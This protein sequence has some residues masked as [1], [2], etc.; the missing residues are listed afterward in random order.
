MKPLCGIAVAFPL[1]MACESLPFVESD[2]PIE[3]IQ[4]SAEP[5]LETVSVSLEKREI[6]V[7]VPPGPPDLLEELRSA[8]ELE[9]EDNARIEAQRNW[10][11]RHPDYLDRVLNRAQRYMP[12]I[13]EELV[14]RELP[15]ELALLPIVESAYDPFA[16][17]H[18]RAAGLWQ[19]IPGTGRRFG[20]EEAAG[21]GLV[22]SVHADPA[23]ARK[24]ALEMAAGIAAKSPLENLMKKN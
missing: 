2:E 20:A 11:V 21:W 6:P 23:A 18:G 1:L 16:Y 12:Y 3:E 4:V 19:I 5:R 15:I 7:W 24:A 8:F 13:R 17:S 10:F 9:Y 22:N 14:R